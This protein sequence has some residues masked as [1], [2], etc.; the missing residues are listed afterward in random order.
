M[1]YITA[2]EIEAVLRRFDFNE[3]G[4]LDYNEFYEMV[5]GYV[6]EEVIVSEPRVEYRTE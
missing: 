1:Y 3:N 2:L 5:M 4:Q 6:I